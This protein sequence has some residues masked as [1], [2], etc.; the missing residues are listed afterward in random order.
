MIEN[1]YSMDIANTN[2]TLIEDVATGRVNY[3][4]SSN[5]GKSNYIVDSY[6]GVITIYE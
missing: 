3:Y 2:M 5:D 4:H 6:T 1:T